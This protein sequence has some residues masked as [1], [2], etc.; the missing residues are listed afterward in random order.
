MK[1]SSTRDI[2]NVM[3]RS[4][5][6]FVKATRIS[7]GLADWIDC[8]NISYL[9]LNYDN[10]IYTHCIVVVKMR[11]SISCFEFYFFK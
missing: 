2:M 10:L 11:V 8:P 4:G 6:Y 7:F 5:T 3:R 1:N 9:F